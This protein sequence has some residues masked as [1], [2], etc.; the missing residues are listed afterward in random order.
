MGIVTERFTGKLMRVHIAGAGLV[1]RK[2]ANSLAAEDHLVS[3]TDPVLERAEELA[4]RSATFPFATKDIDTALA[5]VEPADTAIVATT[6]EQLIPTALPFAQAGCHILV[7]KPGAR[8]PAE[9]A[10]LMDAMHPDRTL[11]VGYNHRFHPA[12]LD[13]HAIAQSGQ[14]GPVRAIRA[15]YGHGGRQGYEKE[16]R[17][18]RER[19]G[20]GELLDQGSHL[21]DLTRFIAGGFRLRSSDLATLYWE[22]EVEDN[23]WLLGELPGG[24]RASLHASW[25][26]WKNLFS[27]EAFFTSA[28]VEVSGLGGSY[29]PEQLIVSHMES[30]LGPPRITTTQY[31]SGDV[32][33]EQEWADFANR[34]AGGNGIG[35]SG[36]DASAVLA[37]T[38]EAY[39]HACH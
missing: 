15:R 9:F 28:K 22:I 35:A 8:T 31:A 36:A 16:W 13:L 5:V 6:H 32:S 24:G 12:F 26:E 2:R 18:D 29:G 11:G 27:F 20:G 3:V 37:I 39:R 33:W 19:S 34:A 38:E 14:F 1:G 4:E 7:E 25:T 23:A 17:A 21:I 30:G 10:E